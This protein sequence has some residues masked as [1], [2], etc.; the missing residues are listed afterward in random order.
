MNRSGEVARFEMDSLSSPP[1]YGSRSAVR[2][3]FSES[4]MHAEYNT[5]YD[6]SLIGNP[7]FYR[8][9]IFLAIGFAVTAFF[10]KTRLQG[11]GNRIF[12]FVWA[13]GWLACSTWFVVHTFRMSREYERMYHAGRCGIAEGTVKVLREGKRNGHDS[14]DRIVIDGVEFEFS[15]FDASRPGYRRIIRRG[16]WLTEGTKARVHYFDGAILKVEIA[17]TDPRM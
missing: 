9:L 4:T 15:Y 6:V 14:G 2:V 17:S 12:L 11:L 7:D 3:S 16:G 10:V 8:G 13:A 5:V 1:G